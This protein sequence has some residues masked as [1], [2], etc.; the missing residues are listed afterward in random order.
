VRAAV[1]L[2][3]PDRGDDAVG[4]LVAERL[5]AAGATLLDC[6]EDPT[7]LVDAWD[8]LELVV[9]VDAVHSGAA[10]GTVHR[11]E[12]GDRP[13]PS[14]IRFASTHA[15]SIADALALAHALGRAPRGVL[16]LGVEGAAFAL[17]DPM[18][19][20]VEA[21]VPRVAADALTALADRPSTGDP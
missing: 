1:C 19:P 14:E 21:A 11:F 20:A 5:R 18:T 12:P 16:V 9:I 17:G 8:G 2:G 3:H 4:P 6:N 10:P 15:F 7:R 13:L